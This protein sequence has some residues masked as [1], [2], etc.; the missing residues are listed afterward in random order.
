MSQ[1]LAKIT[2]ICYEAKIR[3]TS[4]PHQETNDE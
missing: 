4:K 3:E 2:P 1:N